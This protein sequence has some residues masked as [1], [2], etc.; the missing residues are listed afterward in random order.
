ME[1]GVPEREPEGV[2]LDWTGSCREPSWTDDPVRRECFARRLPGPDLEKV[3]GAM[4][5]ARVAG[6]AHGVLVVVGE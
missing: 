1:A 4:L 6:V 3:L 5:V 2:G